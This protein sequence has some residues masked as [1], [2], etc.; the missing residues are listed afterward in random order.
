M[1]PRDVMKPSDVAKNVKWNRPLARGY[2]SLRKMDTAKV[3]ESA[4]EVFE[5]VE[6]EDRP[7]QKTNGSAERVS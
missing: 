6:D 3:Y 2:R 1:K 4:A 7:K 5:R